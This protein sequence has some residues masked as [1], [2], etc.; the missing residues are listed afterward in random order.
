MR[1]LCLLNFHLPSELYL[2]RAF[3]SL[4]VERSFAAYCLCPLQL[5]I[6]YECALFLSTGG[7]YG[8]LQ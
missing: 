7:G 2:N 1:I 4:E 6:L 8:N 5:C 3:E